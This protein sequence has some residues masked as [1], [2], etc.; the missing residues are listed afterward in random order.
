MILNIVEEETR[1]F[2]TA[3]K[4]PYLI[5]IEAFQPQELEL[6]IQDC[7]MKTKPRAYLLSGKKVKNHEDL[8]YSAY[9]R[10]ETGVLIPT[11]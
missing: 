1:L 7:Q 3:E 6:Q 4:A 8:F 2:I 5:Y 11:L 10:L 9:R